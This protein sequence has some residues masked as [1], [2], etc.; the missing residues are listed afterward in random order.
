MSFRVS[1]KLYISKLLTSWNS[2]L[3]LFKV[4]NP[5]ENLNPRILPLK[6]FLM[7]I[8]M[9]HMIIGL[10]PRVETLNFRPYILQINA[11]FRE[12]LMFYQGDCADAQL[13]IS[14]MIK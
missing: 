4:Y 9:E 2:H 1:I 5:V 14:L 8:S 13:Y 10:S 6:L 11:L 12:K 7:E 3:T